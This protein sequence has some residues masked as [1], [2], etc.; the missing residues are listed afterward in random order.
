VSRNERTNTLPRLWRLDDNQTRVQHLCHVEEGCQ[1][2]RKRKQIP[3]AILRTFYIK[4]A[5]GKIHRIRVKGHL[6]N[7]SHLSDPN[8]PPEGAVIELKGEGASSDAG[9]AE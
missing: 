4:D 5:D 2:S 7:Q 1:M 9:A 8:L 3:M 6:R